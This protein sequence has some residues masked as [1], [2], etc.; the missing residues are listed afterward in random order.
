[1]GKPLAPRRRGQSAKL[2][3]EVESE[4]VEGSEGGGDEER[5]REPN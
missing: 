2:G 1:M 3:V 5:P 4:W